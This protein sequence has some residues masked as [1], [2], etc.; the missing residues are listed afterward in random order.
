[1]MQEY[2]S[3]TWLLQNT[4]TGMDV[5]EL[6]QTIIDAPV[7]EFDTNEYD[8]MERR[9]AWVSVDDR[10]PPMGEDVL[11]WD[12]KQEMIAVAWFDEPGVWITADMDLSTASITHWR[13]MPRLPKEVDGDD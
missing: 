9:A 7:V 6:L 12:S 13:Y 4:N 1:M 3:K 8:K 5:I 2:I 10:L 11:V